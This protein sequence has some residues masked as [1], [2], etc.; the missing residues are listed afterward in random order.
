MHFLF[1]G[2]Q[3]KPHE[4][5][6]CALGE[7]FVFIS[8]ARSGFLRGHSWPVIR[9]Y[10]LGLFERGRSIDGNLKGFILKPLYEFLVCSR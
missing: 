5:R 9:S 4:E 7:I 6:H 8:A 2:V 10:C 1:S 3:G